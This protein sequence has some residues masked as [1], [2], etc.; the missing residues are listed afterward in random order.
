MTATTSLREIRGTSKLRMEAL[1]ALFPT[2]QGVPGTAPWDQH[3]F[4]RWAS[5]PA[6]T[7]GSVQAAAFVLAVWNGC[8]PRDGGWWNQRPYRVGRFDIVHALGIWDEAHKSAFLR[9]C[10][11]PFWP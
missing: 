6:A 3:A 2:L 8:T 9:W 4:A 10:D 7:S 11:D 5:G 1:C